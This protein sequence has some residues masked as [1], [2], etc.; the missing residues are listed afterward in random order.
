MGTLLEQ[1]LKDLA[2]KLKQYVQQTGQITNPK[3]NNLI[4]VIVSLDGSWR[5]HLWAVDKTVDVWSQQIR[6]VLD[7]TIK[8]SK[9]LEY[10]KIL[11]RKNED[12]IMHGEYLK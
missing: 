11:H 5:T 4:K 9:C 3:I 7:V 6:E 10:D 8:Y 2:N 12:Q 1:N